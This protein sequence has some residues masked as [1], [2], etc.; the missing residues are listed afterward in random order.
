MQDPDQTIPVPYNYG[1]QGQRPA[2]Q[3]PYGQGQFPPQANGWPST[4]QSPYPHS[5]MPGQQP[6]PGSYNSGPGQF[7]GYQPGPQFPQSPQTPPKKRNLLWAVVG[8]V[9]LLL[10]VLGGLFAFSHSS[11][12]KTSTPNTTAQSSSTHVATAQ[13]SSSQSSTGKNASANSGAQSS[14]SSDGNTVQAQATAVVATVQA[15]ATAAISTAQSQ[16][17]N[18]PAQA[19]STAQAADQVARSFFTAIQNQDYDTAYKYTSFKAFT[20]DSFHQASTASDQSLGKLTAYTIGKTTLYPGT[21]TTNAQVIVSVMRA[22]V[23]THSGLAMLTLQ[24]GTWKITDGT[25]WQ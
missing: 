5:Q 2:Q 18:V 9:V 6:T 23:P 1:G 15:Q 25:V 3:P 11:T 14:A 12:Q 4:P 13:A 17:N 22:N 8:V 16:G 19:Q 20:S 7:S 10:L 24:N 21:N